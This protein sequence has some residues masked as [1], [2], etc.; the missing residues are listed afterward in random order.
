MSDSANEVNQQ[1]TALEADL[2][3]LEAEYNM[4]FAGRLPRPPWETRARVEG[5]VKRLDRSHISNYGVRFRF[6]TLQT[7]LSRFIDL[8]DRALRARA[9]KA[10][11]APCRTCTKSPSRCRRPRSGSRTGS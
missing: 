1:L 2:K 11:P 6:N 5:T 4:Y 7:R 8:W 10:V 3:R 9:R